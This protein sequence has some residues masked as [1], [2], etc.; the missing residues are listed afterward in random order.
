MS[1]R[2]VDI[3]FLNPQDTKLSRTERSNANLAATA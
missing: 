3:Q 1:C 2:R